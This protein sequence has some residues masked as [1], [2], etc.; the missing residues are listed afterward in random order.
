MAGLNGTADE[1]DLT[2]ALERLPTIDAIDVLGPADEIVCRSS[3]Y[4]LVPRWLDPRDLTFLDDLDAD[5]ST[6]GR[7]GVGVGVAWSISSYEVIVCYD[8]FG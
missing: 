8:L 7:V 1:R 4:F 5:G 6:P 2:V 3:G